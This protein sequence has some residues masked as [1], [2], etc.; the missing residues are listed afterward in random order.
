VKRLFYDVANRQRLGM[1]MKSRCDIRF[2]ALVKLVTS[3]AADGDLPVRKLRIGDKIV[4]A[5]G[6]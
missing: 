3:R 1:K 5:L 2:A 6:A 4:R